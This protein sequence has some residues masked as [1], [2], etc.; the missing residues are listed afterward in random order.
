MLLVIELKN[1][2]LQQGK[3]KDCPFLSLEKRLIL[4]MDLVASLGKIVS[5]VNCG[6]FSSPG[7]YKIILQ[8]SWILIT[9]LYFEIC[10]NQLG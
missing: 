2:H 7:F 6:S 8:K 9:H 5:I 4:V 3:S 1:K 10:P